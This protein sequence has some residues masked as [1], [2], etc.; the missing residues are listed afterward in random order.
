ML[1]GSFRRQLEA[2]VILDLGLVELFWPLFPLFGSSRSFHAL[3]LPSNLEGGRT[4]LVVH[5]ALHLNTRHSEITSEGP[6]GPK[7][8]IG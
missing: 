7:K 4:R 2:R 3:Y 1:K 8:S 5:F 6:R